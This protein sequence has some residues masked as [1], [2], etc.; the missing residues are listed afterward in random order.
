[1]LQQEK[2]FDD[3]YEYVDLWASGYVKAYLPDIS[4]QEHFVLRNKVLETLYNRLE[5]VNLLRRKVG[6]REMTINECYD[7]YINHMLEFDDAREEIKFDTYNNDTKL[8][9]QYTSEVEGKAGAKAYLFI[10]GAPEIYLKNHHVVQ[11]RID[12]ANKM[13]TD[14][15]HPEMTPQKIEELLLRILVVNY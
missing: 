14:N 3:L 4:S 15:G 2:Y 12:L 13:L 11:E 6:L 1:M 7:Y 9:N 10:I 8:I 5:V